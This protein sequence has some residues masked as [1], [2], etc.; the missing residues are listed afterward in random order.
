MG[1]LFMF[2]FDELKENVL[3]MSMVIQLAFT[4]NNQWPNHSFPGHSFT[5]QHPP[6]S[7]HHHSHRN[8]RENSEL[9]TAILV[10]A[11][12][13]PSIKTIFIPWEYI[14]SQGIKKNIVTP[15]HLTLWQF[16]DGAEVTG[17]LTTCPLYLTE[18][19]L[20]TTA[21]ELMT[22]L[23]EQ[24]LTAVPLTTHERNGPFRMMK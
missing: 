22:L 24:L 1:I 3:L 8:C 20:Q 4:L 18:G 13:L 21:P 2:S 10:M 12:L 16:L 11:G 5:T 23:P 17:G 14:Y 7:G 19:S 9:P 15:A 6:L